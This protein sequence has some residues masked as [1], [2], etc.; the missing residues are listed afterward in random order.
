MLSWAV[1][2]L[3]Q[4][5]WTSFI[6]VLVLFDLALVCLFGLSFEIEIGWWIDTTIL[7]DAFKSLKLEFAVS[8]L[9][10][11][12]FAKIILLH[13]SDPPKP[14][15]LEFNRSERFFFNLC[16]LKAPVFELIPTSTMNPT[17][18]FCLNSSFV[19]YRVVID[20]VSRSAVHYFEVE[21]RVEVVLGLT[22]HHWTLL[23]LAICVC[24]KSVF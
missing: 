5:E 24:S 20:E 9:L 17:Y 6:P 18:L 4:K 13:S 22:F 19:I 10:N 15:C 16:C 8:Y 21:G 12:E 7:H 3:R 2:D 11:R 1:R 14:S 23:K